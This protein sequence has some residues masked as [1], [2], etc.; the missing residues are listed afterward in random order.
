MLRALVQRANA[1]LALSKEAYER[2]E[3]GDELGIMPGEDD[4]ELIEWRPKL[5]LLLSQQPTSKIALN[6]L[7]L[8][9]FTALTPR[10]LAGIPVLKIPLF[11]M[12]LLQRAHKE[13]PDILM[14]IE[15]TMDR[16]S[17]VL[18]QAVWI[19][20]EL[21]AIRRRELLNLGLKVPM[22]N[23]SIPS[24]ALS[25]DEPVGTRTLG[26]TS[27]H[28]AT[29]PQKENLVLSSECST[30]IERV[31]DDVTET[32]CPGLHGTTVKRLGKYVETVMKD[33]ARR[34]N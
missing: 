3:T 24:I 14:E 6:E 16:Q 15:A 26:T 22:G 11:E 2:R 23:T 1:T 25:T 31:H 4:L 18:E 8:L 33:F 32:R 20:G 19:D 21:D 27:T 10:L 34:Y 17:Q 28:A 5:Q 29:V 7:F 12:E 13:V 30:M 9:L